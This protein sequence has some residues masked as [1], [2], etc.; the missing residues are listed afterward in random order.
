[1]S[2]LHLAFEGLRNKMDE[3]IAQKRS[4]R[5]ADEE[6]GQLANPRLVHREGHETDKRNEAHSDDAGEGKG[7]SCHAAFRQSQLR[8]LWS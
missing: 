4:H 6:R 8:I 3:R 5:K 7:S 1:L 2:P